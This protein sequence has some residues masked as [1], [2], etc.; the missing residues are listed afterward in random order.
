[1]MKTKFKISQGLAFCFPPWQGN[2]CWPAV[3]IYDTLRL[4]SRGTHLNHNIMLTT[5]RMKIFLEG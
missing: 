1:M 5:T 4:C 3:N 2:P